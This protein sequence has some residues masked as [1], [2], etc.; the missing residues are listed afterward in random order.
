MSPLLNLRKSSA[1]RVVYIGRFRSR[2]F[3][4]ETSAFGKSIGLKL[5]YCDFSADYNYLCFSLSVNIY[6]HKLFA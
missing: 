1:T 3:N 4:D 6:Y 5:K 2:V